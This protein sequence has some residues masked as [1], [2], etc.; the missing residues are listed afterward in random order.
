MIFF[1]PKKR[2]ITRRKKARP[3]KQSKF[4]YGFALVSSLLVIFV[5][6]WGARNRLMEAEFLKI[7]EISIRGCVQIDAASLLKESSIQKGRNILSINLKMESS[8]LEQ[9]PWVYRAVVKR[10][11]PDRIDIQIHEHRALAVIRLDDFYLVDEN[12]EI[13]IQTTPNAFNLPLLTGLSNK[14]IDENGD[15]ANRLIKAALGLINNVNRQNK[16]CRSGVTIEMD[17]VFGLTMVSRA[18]SNKISMGFDDFETKLTLLESIL[19]DLGKKGLRAK[20]INLNSVK[21]AYV[22]IAS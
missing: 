21:Q 9:N 8:L 15:E 22:K 12:A 14:D 20:H 11:L 18:D 5:L 2:K 6:A 13:F 7:K 1:R 17:P 3:K 4:I 16:R 10:S 19:K